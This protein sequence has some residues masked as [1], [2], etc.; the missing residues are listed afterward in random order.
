M[1]GVLGEQLLLQGRDA[2][3][4]A[5]S[6]QVCAL[7]HGGVGSPGLGDDDVSALEGLGHGADL[8]EGG[9]VLGGVALG[10]LDDLGHEVVALGVSQGHV[11]AKARQQGDEGLRAGQRLAVGGRVGPGDGDLLALEV[12]QATELLD[13]VEHV[14]GGLGGV[15]GV[16]LQGDQGR[17]VVQDAVVV[18][19]L[20]GLGDLGHVG[21]ALAD[22]HV[23]ADADDVSHEGDHGSGLADGLAVGDLGLLLVQVLKL[24][25]EQVGGLGEG[26]AGAGGVVAEERHG[27]AG[28][29]DLG[30]DVALAQV[31]QGGG[32]GV[33]GAQ[34]VGGLVPGVQEVAAVHALEVKAVQHVDVLL[35]LA[36]V[37][38]LLVRLL[39]AGHGGPG[40]QAPPSHN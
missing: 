16:G 22:V 34:L 19:L 31:A 4:V 28:V 5:L 14:G 27:Q 26:E 2:G 9:A 17:T 3:V 36:H 23:V 6:V 37:V 39:G 29:E 13:E 38:P 40:W 21:V 1:G 8:L 18:G 10:A 35:D 15:V 11:H 25:A 32:G 30:G 7:L 33:E 20:H 24:E 12:L